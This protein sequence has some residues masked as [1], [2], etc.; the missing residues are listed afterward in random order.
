MRVLIVDHDMVAGRARATALSIWGFKT[1]TTDQ[2]EEGL[3]LGTR[4]QYDAILLDPELAD[5]NG[6]RLITILRL[7]HIPTPILV[8]ARACIP[9]DEALYLNLGADDYVSKH[10]GEESLVARIRGLVRR[11]NGHSELVIE[12]G[13][14][15]LNLLTHEAFANGE[16]IHLTKK[17]YDLLELFMLKKGRLLT[18]EKIMDNLYGG[19]DEPDLKIVDVFVCKLR[20][21]LVQA[22][23][24]VDYLQTVWG[25]GYIMRA[26]AEETGLKSAAA[27]VA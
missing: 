8:L 6:R 17:E 5:M 11:A 9:Q 27:N 10:I 22:C 15:S 23:G 26:T 16:H 1:Y 7:R 2:G 18:N 20:K 21:K 12:V 24:E 4:Y 3:D 14:I 13:A 19:I 25:Q